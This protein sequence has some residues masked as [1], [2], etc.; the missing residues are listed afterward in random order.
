ME[1]TELLTKL[2]TPREVDQKI[3]EFI[4]WLRHKEGIYDETDEEYLF[5]KGIFEEEEEI[6][7]DI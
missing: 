2:L 7:K 1:V 3:K 6:I 5:T 4:Q